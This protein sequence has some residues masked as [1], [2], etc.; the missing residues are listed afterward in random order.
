M[1]ATHQYPT[2]LGRYSAMHRNRS[3]NQT[4]Q[5]LGTRRRGTVLIIAVVLL[6][7]ATGLS[8]ELLRGVVA[9]ARQLR[10][11]CQ[12]VQAERL[13]EAGLARAAVRLA[14]DRS[15]TGEEWTVQLPDGAGLVRIRITDSGG[16]RS[17][18]ATAV[19]PAGKSRPATLTRSAI[20]PA[21]EVL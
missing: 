21:A 6:L 16:N 12:T 9:D 4:P 7:V 15:Y 13:A 5:R 20:L 18:Q 14:A 1:N 11:D 8:A 17:V 10:S 19:W 2:E 3:T